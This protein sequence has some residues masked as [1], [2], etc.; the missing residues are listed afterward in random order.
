MLYGISYGLYGTGCDG[1]GH[2]AGQWSW[3]GWLCGGG[4]WSTEVRAG[5]LTGYGSYKLCGR[6][7]WGVGVVR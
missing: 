6:R 2:G 5:W 7:R 3:W 4:Y 1:A